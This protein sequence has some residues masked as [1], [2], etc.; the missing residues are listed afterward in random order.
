LGTIGTALFLA[1]LWRSLKAGMTVARA[2]PEVDD[3]L[4]KFGLALLTSIAGFAVSAVFISVL[5]Y[6]PFWHLVALGAVMLGMVR[7]TDP[8]SVKAVAG[9]P[10][11]QLKHA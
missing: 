4:R 7:A 9:G 1:L 3:D 8:V 6:P 2:G 10:S 11:R 5:Y